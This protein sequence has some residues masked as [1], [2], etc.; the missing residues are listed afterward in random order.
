MTLPKLNLI[1]R[2]ASRNR[3]GWDK[4]FMLWL[5]S[6]VRDFSIVHA[7]KLTD[8]LITFFDL[9]GVPDSTLRG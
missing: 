4:F 9:H 8:W 2:S 7:L 3:E 5:Q 1:D 6:D